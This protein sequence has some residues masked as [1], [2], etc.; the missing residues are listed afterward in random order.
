MTTVA[1][2]R[3]LRALLWLGLPAAGAGLGW[4]AQ[5]IA[6]WVAALPAAPFQGPFKLVAALPRPYGLIVAVAV[7]AAAGLVLAFLAHVDTLVVTVRADRVQLVRGDVTD[8]FD[9][10]A[11]V[12]A[13][14]DQGELVLLSADGHELA[15]EKHDLDARRLAAAFGARGIRWFDRDPYEGDFRR[16]VE[17][18]PGLSAAANALLKARAKVLEKGDGD[19]DLRQLRHE[20]TRLDVAVRDRKKRQ[21]WRVV[22]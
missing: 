18:T 22:S 2:P 10:R 12:A 14:T 16:W 20:L 6:S 1:P 19:D 3:W 5:A 8:V 15:R 7:G 9:R 13:F 17:D 4:G 11:V 21:F